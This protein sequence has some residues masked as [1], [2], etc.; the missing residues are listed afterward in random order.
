M[1]KDRLS[2][3]RELL[4][5]AAWAAYHIVVVALSAAIAMAL[6]TIANGMLA[7][8]SRTET[9][10]ALLI[11]IEIAVASILIVLLTYFY[12][13]IQDRLLA[14]MANGAGLVAFFPT[15][16]LQDQKRIRTLKEREGIGRNIMVIGST[17]YGTFVDP[18]GD[19]SGVLETCLEAKLLLV[20]PYWD[21]ASLRVQAL[22]HPHFSLARFRSEVLESIEILKK[23]RATGK[24][25]R[26]KLYSDPPLVKLVI[27][28][29]YLW[30]KHYHTD[31]DVQT[32]PEYVFRHNQAD[33]GLYTLFYQYFL[34]RWESTEIPEYDFDTDDL[35]YRTETGAERLR[36]RFCRDAVIES[37]HALGSPASGDHRGHRVSLTG[38]DA[39]IVDTRRHGRSG[40][41]RHVGTR[42]ELHRASV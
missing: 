41:L 3:I 32:M 8:W 37:A 9:E 2:G 4:S 16:G 21:T 7:F 12:R 35:V 13:S 39:W 17:G 26:L 28:G 42:T 38:R 1:I 14:R 22:E 6:P 24:T 40:H 34:Q 30:V 36:E 25:I 20:N 33:H 29:D 19:L 11:G 15:R 27:L 10:K 31:L 18:A 5:D 23:L